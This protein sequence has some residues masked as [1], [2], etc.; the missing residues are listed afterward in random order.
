MLF[1]SLGNF[2]NDIAV[3]A[4]QF[5]QRVGANLGIP[6]RNTIMVLGRDDDVLHARFLGQQHP[7]FRIDALPIETLRQFAVFRFA[8]AVPIAD[9]LR[10]VVRVTQ[11]LTFPDSFRRTVEAPMDEHAKPVIFQPLFLLLGHA[12]GYKQQQEG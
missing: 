7:F 11:A 6:K 1:A 9:P 5:R 8:N 2:L 10:I 3:G 12:Q 4:A